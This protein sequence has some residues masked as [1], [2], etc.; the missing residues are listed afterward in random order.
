MQSNCISCLCHI[1]Y[2]NKEIRQ[3]YL[4]DIE[5]YRLLF[6]L[7]LISYN[8]QLRS[9]PDQTVYSNSQEDLAALMFILLYNQVSS[10][11]YYYES[12]N[13]SQKSTNTNKKLILHF[14]LSSN[15]KSN[16]IEPFTTSGLTQSNESFVNKNQS[17]L[18]QQEKQQWQAY[19]LNYK[20]NSILKR[21]IEY[22]TDNIHFKEVLERKFRL[23]WNIYWHGGSLSKLCNDLLNNPQLIQTRDA[24][25]SFSDNLCLTDDD[26]FHLKYSNP[27][28]LIKQFCDEITKCATHEDALNLLDLSQILITIIDGNEQFNLGIDSSEDL[29]AEN[30]LSSFFN[31]QKSDWHLALNRFASILPSTKSKSDLLLF[32]NSFQ[33]ISK[34]LYLQTNY[35][36]SHLTSLPS[37][38]N[39]QLMLI[40]PDT[41]LDEINSIES[42]DKWLFNMTYN[43]SSSLVLMIK[44]FLI[45]YESDELRIK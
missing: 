27:F 40:S 15:L 20:L 26:K 16:L 38:G 1:F 45:D 14:D 8:M 44:Q 25:P 21:K 5:F 18:K 34:L 9:Q 43:P 30:R 19:E 6:K 4:F 36:D 28:Y 33:T 3:S 13:D 37:S 2:W 10:L 42:V 39:K 12:I 31:R 11:D 32:S 7:L 22:C 29:D 35:Y 17:E 23:Y 41:A 24:S